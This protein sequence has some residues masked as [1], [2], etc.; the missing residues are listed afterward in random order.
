VIRYGLAGEL[1][2][3]L[4]DESGFE[5]M[6]VQAPFADGPRWYS[7]E[8]HYA[9]EKGLMEKFFEPSYQI[10]PSQVVVCVRPPIR[11]RASR[12][13]TDRPRFAVS[14]AAV[15]P[16]KPAPMTITS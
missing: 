5:D 7:M 15:I 6:A 9:R 8:E 1:V 13:T 16:A 14:R 12:M 10:F 3:G 2:P 4:G 11:S